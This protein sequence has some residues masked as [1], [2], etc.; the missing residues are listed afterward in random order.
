MGQAINLLADWAA[1]NPDRNKALEENI[2]VLARWLSD[3][4][5]RHA[6][7]SRCLQKTWTPSGFDSENKV[8][9][10]DDFVKIKE[11]CLTWDSST[12][13]AIVPYEVLINQTITSP[14]VYSIH[15]GFLYI[16]GAT[17]SSTPSIVYEYR[18]IELTVTTIKTED[19]ELPAEF[20]KTLVLYLD[21]M[22]A[23]TKDDTAGYMALMNEFRRE[24]QNDGVTNI[25]NRYGVP[26]MRP[27]WI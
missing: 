5:V 24:A 22:W 3:A 25:E 15:N 16:P 7:I 12:V 1:L 21:A 4:Q 2:K 8:Q 19:L 10:P 20:H 26:Q 23:R 17:S 18:P 9:L 11:D 27:S 6:E 13:L 14:I